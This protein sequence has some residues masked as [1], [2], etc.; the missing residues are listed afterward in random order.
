MEICSHA[1]ELVAHPAH[2]HEALRVCALALDLAAQV[3]DMRVYRPLVRNEVARPQ[4]LCQL[5]AREH[6]PGL[7]GEHAEELELGRRQRL[8][9][10]VDLD[11]VAGQVER[12]VAG[13]DGRCPR[14][15][16]ELTPT[17]E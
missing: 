7:A 11:L 3:R 6:A 14:T 12:E 8:A 17:Q 5:A 15:A 2:R 10:P 1:G 9:A 13:T 4:V 16:V